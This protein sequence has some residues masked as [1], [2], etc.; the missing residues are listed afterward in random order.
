MWRIAA[1]ESVVSEVSSRCVLLDV[2]IDLCSFPYSLHATTRVAWGNAFPCLPC[3]QQGIPLFY[4]C[5]GSFTATMFHFI[6]FVLQTVRGKKFAFLTIATEQ[7]NNVFDESI[8]KWNK[9][10][11]VWKVANKNYQGFVLLFP[12]LNIILAWHQTAA[13]CWVRKYLLSL[14]HWYSSLLANSKNLQ[15]IPLKLA[16]RFLDFLHSS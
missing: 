4:S 11:L 14:G 3:F 15:T 8:K 7:P 9:S 10:N 13:L 1:V 2:M 16:T 12:K 6:L 5:F